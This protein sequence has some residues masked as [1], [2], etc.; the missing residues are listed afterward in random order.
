MGN[1]AGQEVREMIRNNK[2][3]TMRDRKADLGMHCQ[4]LKV[5]DW[6]MKKGSLHFFFLCSTPAVSII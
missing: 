4:N 3:L 1:E 6:T 5:G 2:E